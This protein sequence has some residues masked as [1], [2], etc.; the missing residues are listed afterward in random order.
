MP[1]LKPGTIVP[2]A[3][4]DKA[5]AKAI[6]QDPDTVDMSSPEGSSL[7]PV[8]RDRP[9]RPKMATP[10]VSLTVRYDVD[11][12]N[13]FKAF[14]PGWQTRMNAALREWLRTHHR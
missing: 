6:A 5:I 2:T 12:V 8:A 10:K 1:K 7:E 9:G 3:Q 13:A 14:G 4:E 11:I